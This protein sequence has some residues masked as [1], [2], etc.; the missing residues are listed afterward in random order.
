[1]G[2]INVE[3]IKFALETEKIPEEDV[4]PTTRKLII[5]C[6]KVVEHQRSKR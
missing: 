6:K 5:Y 2:G 1:M 3:G 4:L